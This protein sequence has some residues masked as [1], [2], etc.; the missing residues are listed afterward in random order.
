MITH[1]SSLAA[2]TAFFSFTFGPSARVK[3]RVW[4]ARLTQIMLDGI[5]VLP[6]VIARNAKENGVNLQ[7]FTTN[8]NSPDHLP[9]G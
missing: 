6:L 2:Q 5:I 8:Q 7:L 3:K 4:A 9:Q 1:R